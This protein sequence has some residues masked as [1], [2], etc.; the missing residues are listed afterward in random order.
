M[1][2][3]RVI[4]C[5][6]QDPKFYRKKRNIHFTKNNFILGIFRPIKTKLK[7]KYLYKF[8]QTL[9]QS[10]KMKTKTLKRED[11]DDLNALIRGPVISPHIGVK[12]DNK[13]IKNFEFFGELLEEGYPQE[14]ISKDLDEE[15]H[16]FELEISDKYKPVK[17]EV[18]KNLEKPDKLAEL[19]K[20]EDPIERGI[21]AGSLRVT[22][23]MPEESVK[24]IEEI[25]EALGNDSHWYVRARL[26]ENK[27]LEYGLWGLATPSTFFG[28]VRDAGNTNI[29]SIYENFKKLREKL[30][31]DPDWRV[32]I[33]AIR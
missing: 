16:L 2:L 3:T 11:V 12:A 29:K 8:K 21:V 19:S 23:N 9:I 27:R 17:A 22:P 4:K 33:E 30:K 5:K 31:N 25:A 18:E 13:V 6:C 20:S 28:V 24:K 32:R 14:R 1:D 26:L 7:K 15:L 10:D